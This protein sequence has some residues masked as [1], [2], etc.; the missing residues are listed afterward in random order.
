MVAYNKVLPIL[1][2]AVAETKATIRPI[3]KFK[4]P[5]DKYV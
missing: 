5:G 4:C 2:T 3:D 1:L